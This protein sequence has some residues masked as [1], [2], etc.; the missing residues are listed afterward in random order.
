M[1]AMARRYSGHFPDPQNPRLHLPRVR[2]FQ[3]WNEQNFGIY[4]TSRSKTEIPRVY[5]RLLNAGYDAVKRVSHS[6][7]VVTG[8]LGPYGYNGT[9]VD[10][11]PQQFMRAML[12]LTGR[13]GRHLRER[14]RCRTP[15]PKFDV[16][17]QHPYT[18]GGRPTTHGGS[19]DSVALGDLPEVRRTVAFAVHARKVAP[20]RSKKLWVSE[21]GWFTNPPGLLSG[22]GVQLGVSPSRQAAYLSETAY[23]VWR[24]GFSAFVWY[25]LDDSPGFPTGLVR[26]VTPFDPKPSFTAMR[27]PFYGNARRG[28]VLVWGIAPGRAR[29]RIMVERRS[30]G[31]WLRV[32]SVRSDARGMFYRWVDGPPGSYRAVVTAGPRRGSA[33]LSFHAR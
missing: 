15:K 19:A 11:E 23:R 14:S 29:A 4:L 25:G 8:G 3:M 16:W 13:G 7:V 28:R 20:A 5:V 22:S 31:R 1:R 9:A 26:R 30:D 33:S 32:R 17:A 18:F 27:V 6:N 10:V 24:A 2:Y 21:F 12:C